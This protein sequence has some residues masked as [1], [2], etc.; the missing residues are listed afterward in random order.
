MW[1]KSNAFH[2]AN[3]NKSSILATILENDDEDLQH[4]G[5]DNAVDSDDDRVEKGCNG[6]DD[7]DDDDSTCGKKKRSSWKVCDIDCRISV[8]TCA[9]VLEYLAM[10]V[11]TSSIPHYD[12]VVDEEDR[13]E[14]DVDRQERLLTTAL[15]IMV[16][17]SSQ[18]PDPLSLSALGWAYGLGAGGGM[19]DW[20]ACNYVP[21]DIGGELR[22]LENTVSS[23]VQIDYGVPVS[24]YTMDFPATRFCT[25]GGLPPHKQ[26][27]APGA[28]WQPPI[29][30][31]CVPSSC[32]SRDLLTLFGDDDFRENLLRHS[33]TIEKSFDSTTSL[34]IGNI[35]NVT[36]SIESVRIPPAASRR[37][38]YVS[39]LA[40][41]ISTGIKFKMGIQCAGETGL[42]ELDDAFTGTAFR[43]YDYW[44]TI[45]LIIV[46]LCFVAIGTLTSGRSKDGERVY[47][48]QS[49]ENANG[50]AAGLIIDD[51][52]GDSTNFGGDKYYGS[53]E[54]NGFLQPNENTESNEK[55]SCLTYLGKCVL[56]AMR[57]IE[58]GIASS[59]DLLGRYFAPF[60]ATQSFFE[61]TRMSRGSR[62]DDMAHQ[63]TAKA[64]GGVALD[65]AY[66]SL[67]LFPSFPST[68]EDGND[69]EG[70]AV[71]R[72][73]SVS[74]SQILN[75]MR[76]ISML[77]IILGHTIGEYRLSA[78]FVAM[79]S[80][81]RL[82][83]SH[84]RFLSPFTI[85]F[86][87]LCSCPIQCGVSESNG[88][89]S[90]YWYDCL[91]ARNVLLQCTL[92]GRYILFHWWIPCDEWD[93]EGTFDS[94]VH[95]QL[96][97]TY[98]DSYV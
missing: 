91:D 82:I 68:G 83:V 24:N 80:P 64:T 41:S 70:D 16:D 15:A 49:R 25:V 66:S 56:G 30:G 50:E 47:S 14:E 17:A 85:L 1:N 84:C 88:S 39:S 78:A 79:D 81:A 36:T 74:S 2:F 58:C 90:A 21:G 32:T 23:K 5:D 18:G 63:Q 45:G 40:L 54:G 7:S 46:L 61:I 34:D 89:S 77:W 95:F 51:S 22:E 9:G 73:E 11:P 48:K 4:A 97:L 38:K 26:P 44:C 65:R 98:W 42:A 37:Y 59:L 52:L 3:N 43:G 28:L 92:C 29:A 60:D 62:Y 27:Y 67:G 12:N 19:G 71:P 72:S 93:V 13:V 87:A 96:K 35:T 31:I 76:S 10:G 20:G 53:T 69:M 57:S 86:D 55:E 8:Q 75:G 94:A 33:A 6:D